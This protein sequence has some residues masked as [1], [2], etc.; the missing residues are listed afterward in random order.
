V[1]LSIL[2]GHTAGDPMDEIDR[3]DVVTKADITVELAKNIS[4][5]GLGFLF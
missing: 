5:M 4:L 2:K 1:F 3:F